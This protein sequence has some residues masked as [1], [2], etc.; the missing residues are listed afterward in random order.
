[1]VELVI[2]ETS[3][4][5]KKKK[6]SNVVNFGGIIQIRETGG[7]FESEFVDV[8]QIEEIVPET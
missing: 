5:N 3:E 8:T 4:A 7:S 2:E 6:L 1:M